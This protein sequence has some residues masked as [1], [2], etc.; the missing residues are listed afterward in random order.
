MREII[1]SSLLLISFDANA[2]QAYFIKLQGGVN[3]SQM[4]TPASTEENDIF[5]G[6]KLNRGKTFQ[7]GLGYYLN[8]NFSIGFTY[9]QQNRKTNKYNYYQENKLS[10]EEFLSEITEKANQ[11]VN[12]I[13][14]EIAEL[15][16]SESIVNFGAEKAGYRQDHEET[17]KQIDLII[18]LHQNAKTKLRSQALMVEA[19]YEFGEHPCLVP[20]VT[21]GV[22]GV[23]HKLGA[24]NYTDGLGNSASINGKQKLNMAYSVGVGLKMPINNNIAFDL[25]GSY[26]D[27]GEI[28]S[29][30]ELTTTFNGETDQEQIE[31]LK[32]HLHG[33]KFM[34]GV[35]F[36]F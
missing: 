31:P 12:G 36:S 20:Y 15:S 29:N 30:T 21:A 9:S 7:V 24:F 33:F 2:T 16:E 3:T 10:F 34:V 26:Y 28:K 22:G 18:A 4:K 25:S 8:K 32:M 35:R 13:S 17:N 6:S 14:P 19:N 27:H 1:S 23:F 11:E 5:S